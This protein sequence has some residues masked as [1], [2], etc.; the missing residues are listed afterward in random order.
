MN[1]PARSV[2]VEERRNAV[3]PRANRAVIPSNTDM[4]EDSPV[5]AAGNNAVFAWSAKLSKPEIMLLEQ[6]SAKHA[7]GDGSL[8]H[9]LHR[10]YGSALWPRKTVENRVGGVSPI[11][12][13]C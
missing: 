2:A 8:R 6:I 3:S 1:S 5:D 9:P 7:Q 11:C 4:T 13:Q 10:L 12:L